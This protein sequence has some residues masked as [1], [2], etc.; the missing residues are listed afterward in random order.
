MKH[1]RTLAEGLGRYL[2]WWLSALVRW[3]DP[4]APMTLRRAVV[5]LL[6]MPLFLLVQLIHIGLPAAG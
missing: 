2:G 3:R 4:L 5:L 6:G 1:L